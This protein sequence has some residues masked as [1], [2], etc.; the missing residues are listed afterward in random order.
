M[1]QDLDD[2][3]LPNGEYRSAL[4]ISVGKSE[5]DDIGALETALGNKLVPESNLLMRN[6]TAVG[7]GLLTN[8]YG[9][10]GQ[11]ITNVS[12]NYVDQITNFPFFINIAPGMTIFEDVI[13]GLGPETVLV[14]R[15]IVASVAYNVNGT[16]AN[17]TTITPVTIFPSLGGAKYRYFG[18]NEQVLNADGKYSG[19][20]F[21]YGNYAT[22][23]AGGVVNIE[24]GMTFNTS[25]VSA[26]DTVTG[27]TY[28]AL[29]NLTKITYELKTAK[30]SF[31]FLPPT[32]FKF[33]FPLEVIGFLSDKSSSSIYTFL[34]DN[35]SALGS[36]SPQTG[37][38]SHH[39]IT[40]YVPDSDAGG[41]YTIAAEGTFLN[42][43]QQSLITGVNL[44]ENLLFWTDNRNQPRKINITN[45]SSY[46]T[47]ENQISVAKYN[48]YLPISLLNQTEVTG[49]SSAANVISL[50]SRNTNIKTG[51]LMVSTNTPATEY[52][53][54]TAVSMPVAAPWT[55]TLNANPAQVIVA[56]NTV[57]F[58]ATTMTGADISTFF[59]EVEMPATTTWPGDPDFLESR[60]V[61]FSYRFQFD[62]G[63]YSIMAPFTQIAYIPKQK[64]YFLNGDEDSTYRSTIVDFMENG[65]Q[66]VNLL[67]PLPDTG[68]NLVSKKNYKINNIE[69]LYK[70]SDQ[71]SVKVLDAISVASDLGS[72]S[73]NSYTY[74]YQSRKP[75]RTL[76]QSQT[77]R[78]Y[79]KVPVRAF[80]QEVS[81][82]RVIYGNFQTQHTPPPNINY[83]VTS[84]DKNTSLQTNWAEYPNHSLKQNRN[85]QVGFVL[86]D[87]YGRSSSVLLSS[88]KLT[89]IESGGIQYGGSTV[90]V[91][92][93]TQT[94]NIKDWFGEALQVV[95]Q[96][97]ITQ[98]ENTATGAPG[99]YA[100][101]IGT[102]FNTF[103]A[104]T[105]LKPS[106]S[107]VSTTTPIGAV[108]NV[109]GNIA[110]SNN[111]ALTLSN[112]GNSAIL[113]GMTVSGA[114]ISDAPHITEVISAN[115]FVM[116]TAQTIAAATR[117]LNYTVNKYTINIIASTTTLT[118]GLSN[119]TTVNIAF[120]SIVAPGMSVLG[121][122]TITPPKVVSVAADKLSIVITGSVVNLVAGVTLT[123][124]NLSNLPVIGSYLRGEYIDFT[125]VLA[126]NGPFLGSYSNIAAGGNAGGIGIQL[127]NLDF[128]I[129]VG[130]IITGLTTGNGSAV[131]QIFYSSGGGTPGV[132]A[133][134]MY[135]Y[136]TASVSYANN[137]I[138]T[139]TNTIPQTQFEIYTREPVNSDIYLQSEP[140]TPDKKYAY[141]LDTDAGY[142]AS[143]WY[144]YKVVVR[145]QE[146]DY[147]NVY[148]PG[149]VKGY[150]DQTNV[151]P[152]IDFPNDPEGSTSNII[153]FNDNINK[154]PRDLSEVGPD[155][156]QFR[157]SVQLF[158]RVQNTMVTNVPGNIQYFPGV[159]TDTAISISAAT[160][161]NMAYE[162][163]SDSQA[164]QQLLYSTLSVKGQASMYQLD[165]NPLIARLS[166]SSAIGAI[167]FDSANSM[168][169]FLAV[170][171]TE[172]QESLLDIFWETTQS[173]LIAD[174]NAD[175]LNGFDG[176]AAFSSLSLVWS[177]S[178]VAG[179][180]ITSYFYP[181]NA[182]GVELPQIPSP[183]P[184]GISTN[185]IPM[186]MTVLD[187]N[188]DIVEVG[189]TATSRIDLFQD[190]VVGSVNYGRYKIILRSP[191][192]YENT[193]SV[194]DLWQFTFTVSYQTDT[195][196]I[197]QNLAMTNVQPSFTDGLFFEN[198]IVPVNLLAVATRAAN[199]GSSDVSGTPALNTTGLFYSIS[200]G[201]DDSYFQISQAGVITKTSI[202]VPV[203]NYAI[204]IKVQDAYDVAATPQV[205]VGSLSRSVVQTITVGPAPTNVGIGEANCFQ[206]RTPNLA[207]LNQI[208]APYVPGGGTVVTGIWYLSDSTLAASEFTGNVPTTN[209]SQSNFLHK[210]GGK[211]TRGTVVFSC[212][213][214]QSFTNNNG[215]LLGSTSS[216]AQWQ[217][218][219]R[220][221]ASTA[222][223]PREDI[224][225]FTMS[226]P[227]TLNLQSSTLTETQFMQ[228]VF[229]FDA[230]GE[231]YI[232]CK[233]AST[234]T[235][236]IATDAMVAWVNS[237]DLNYSTCVVQNGLPVTN[238]NSP[239]RYK[240]LL[241]APQSGYNCA[242]GNTVKYA[243]HPY[244][245]YV[246]TFYNDTSLVTVF[247]PTAD[248]FYGFRTDSS[249]PEPFSGLPNSS[250]YTQ[251]SAKF[252]QAGLKI[253]SALIPE[254]CG[255]IYARWCSGSSITCTHPF[256]SSQ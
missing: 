86:A 159:L 215:G 62:D 176:P 237:N 12:G 175:V 225:G 77:V 148:L 53:Y 46:Y 206:T 131:Q 167:S 163:L 104:A 252:N 78:V 37:L 142:N 119:G 120:N 133:F 8:L 244:A 14:P 166:T 88:V 4:N 22:D 212:N 213:M 201:N 27:S 164:A 19:T 184:P 5:A 18:A 58:L 7:T 152:K 76:P 1:N 229:A 11:G 109:G 205:G 245:N 43:S 105:A 56:A 20:V 106:I 64:G 130:D 17:T 73:D 79:D 107:V 26:W 138:I 214:S 246:S 117:F 118:T 189:N 36:Y 153:L 256:V 2:R 188:G 249:I 172:P 84:G 190:G 66:N 239:K 178:N 227:Q 183:L 240:Y 233:Q 59:N 39:Y 92:Y 253:D 60:F 103:N 15:G 25:V 154:V 207:G 145:Q 13:V 127:D 137:D 221:N 54:V 10:T 168:T 226:I 28:T 180:F 125:E 219:W 93:N 57:T 34:T 90:Y 195:A 228:I 191:N 38:G 111:K 171:E 155:Q 151:S 129:Q 110:V 75:F 82:N 174:L 134:N 21:V 3:L 113:K 173:G 95:V 139:F 63:E 217:V 179:D 135:L 42:F 74:N 200:A 29:N 143:G 24:K 94:S 121:T 223:A 98:L 123:F 202:L 165:S 216:G 146:Q 203:G 204:T 122:G 115:S 41:A 128:N 69:I 112:T 199:N 126:T 238:S 68:V 140:Q 70:E 211:L 193:S 156:K 55:V 80:S 218:Y 31:Q 182:S 255:G 102:G 170:Y 50:S 241:S 83:Y 52:L 96:G 230:V 40:K 67:V 9:S 72:T 124:Y 32:L 132:P 161:A 220:P 71:T 209:S 144:S 177:E 150:P 162:I 243:S 65:V 250:T 157:S 197:Q 185:G 91:P 45:P 232:V 194:L 51:M 30:G 97:S 242:T 181:V 248:E 6:A 224:N 116:S 210:L 192:T 108:G 196:V 61:R 99:L 235:A 236:N 147:Y 44:L 169:P 234:N 87:K 100:E 89:G 231:Y 35:N 33:Y 47:K 149:I 48:P 101:P 198:V 49:A 23:T 160:D 85:Y 186:T 247:T 114:G 16:G 251:I 141:T 136:A 187:G 208:T 158:G 222:W 254:T 81:G